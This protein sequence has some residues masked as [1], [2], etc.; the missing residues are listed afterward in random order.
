M[1]HLLYKDGAEDTPEVLLDR[2]GRVAL[3]QCQLCGRAEVELELPCINFEQTRGENAE[4]RK[5][6]EEQEGRVAMAIDAVESM[7]VTCKS[8]S[9]YRYNQGLERVNSALAELKEPKP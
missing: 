1:A 2:N 8:E 4:L 9:V 3:A 6:C 7:L 5:L